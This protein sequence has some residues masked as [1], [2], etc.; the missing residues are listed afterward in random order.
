[1]QICIGFCLN[2]CPRRWTTLDSS[3]TTE[4]HAIIPPTSCAA[5]EKRPVPDT[6]AILGTWQ[7]GLGDKD[8]ARRTLNDPL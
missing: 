6:G 1:M 8:R 2:V 7:R 4:A 3:N 5:S